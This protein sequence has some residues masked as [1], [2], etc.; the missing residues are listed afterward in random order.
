MSGFSGIPSESIFSFTK[1]SIP[2]KLHRPRIQRKLANWTNVRNS[3][4]FHIICNLDYLAITL[5][6]LSG[7]HSSRI[8]LR[9]PLFGD[10]NYNLT[11]P[12]LHIHV[13]IPAPLLPSG[14]PIVLSFFFGGGGEEEARE[15]TKAM[16]TCRAYNYRS[17]CCLLAYLFCRTRVPNAFFIVK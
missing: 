8:C 10:R 7:A 2:M 12:F 6:V 17:F 13:R 14:P 15:G 1:F 5:C 11:Y 9:Y 3:F 4:A 16:A